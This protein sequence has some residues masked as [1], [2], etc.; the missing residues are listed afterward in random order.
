MRG[1]DVDGAFVSPFNPYKWGDAFV[2]GNSLQYTW[3]VLHD[4]EGLVDA[5]G[6]ERSFLEMLDSVFSAPPVYDASFY[7]F[8][9]HEITEMQAAGTGNYAHGNQPSQ[10]ITYLY[11]WTSRPWKTQRLVRDI[12]DRLYR[13]TPDGYC[14]DEDNGQTSAWYVFSALGFYPVCPGTTQYAVGSPLFRKAVITRP[15]GVKIKV[16]AP[17][18]APDVPYVEKMSVN[19]KNWTRNYIEHG[20]LVKG[21]RIKFKMGSE[22][23]R[24]RGV[25]P[26]ERP[27]SF[28][29]EK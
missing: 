11:D 7:G 17:R 21:G 12:M 1:R 25:K 23:A 28:S 5:M 20:D 6:G 8:R 15:Y 26:E 29:R 19:G 16:S 18:N 22:P 13:A 27:Y 3:S 4:V 2:E 10:H 9:I 24:D 14:G